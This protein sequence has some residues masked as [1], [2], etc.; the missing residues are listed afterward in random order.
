MEL[1]NK[2]GKILSTLVVAVPL[3]LASS[4]YAY[5]MGKNTGIRAE[6]ERVRVE[7]MRNYNWE[8]F[9]NLFNP[10]AH[11]EDVDDVTPIFNEQKQIDFYNHAQF[12]K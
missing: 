9:S 3:V 6:R 4:F 11:K 12:S 1:R 2:T 7:E 5:N 10:Y 8:A